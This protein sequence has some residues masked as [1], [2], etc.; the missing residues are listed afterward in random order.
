MP[1]DEKS[2]E[3]EDVSS[4][5]KTPQAIT[6]T[7]MAP[8][9]LESPSYRS[10]VTSSAEMENNAEGNSSLVVV[11]GD[12]G[13]ITVSESTKDLLQTVTETH[14]GTEDLP[15]IS[16][17]E[18]AAE[19]TNEQSTIHL[20]TKNEQLDTDK[21][22]ECDENEGIEETSGCRCLICNSV[23]QDEVVPV[24]KSM[25]IASQRKVSVYL[26]NLVGHKLTSRKAH[27][28]IICSHCF[29]LLNRLDLLEVEIRDTKELIVNKYQETVAIYGGRARKRKPVAAKKPDYVFPKIEPENE[30]EQAIALEM[31][32]TFEPQVDD[33]MEEEHDQK[34]DR[35]TKDE[36][37]EPEYKR[38][39]IKR[40]P[41]EP[42][43][44]GPPK[45]KRG[46]P[47]KDMSKSKGKLLED[48][49][50]L[51]STIHPSMRRTVSV[52]AIFKKCPHCTTIFME[53]TQLAIHLAQEHA[54][55]QKERHCQRCRRRFLTYED[56]TACEPCL[57]SLRQIALLSRKHKEVCVGSNTVSTFNC[58][59]CKASFNSRVL[60]E[61]HCLSTGHNMD[62]FR[63]THQ[64]INDK[65]VIKCN[66]PMS[67]TDFKRDTK[68]SEDESLD[69]EKFQ[70]TKEWISSVK[71]IRKLR[72]IKKNQRACNVC[73]TEFGS[74][75]TLYSH[76]RTTHPTLFP[77]ECGICKQRFSSE[78][79]AREHERRHAMGDLQCPAC[80]LRFSHISHLHHHARNQHPDFTDYRC[81]YCDAVTPSVD[82]LQSHIKIHHGDQLG[83]PAAFTC[84]TCKETF[85][86]GK[87]LASHRSSRHPGNTECSICGAKVGSR[88]LKKHINAV[89]TKEKVHKCNE[90]GV[91]FY[92]RTSLTGHQRRHHSPRKFFCHLCG[93]G[94]VHNVELQRHLKAHRDERDFKCEFCS[95]SFLKAVDLTYHRRSHTGERPHQCDLCP[96]SFIRPLGLRK[97]MM[98][99]SSFKK[100]K[101]IKYSKK[102]IDELTSSV[103][104]Q[105]SEEHTAGTGSVIKSNMKATETADRIN[106]SHLPPVINL[107]QPLQ[108]FPSND[109]VS[110][111]L[112]QPQ[113]QLEAQVEQL[114][115]DELQVQQL[116]VTDLDSSQ[117]EL[118][119][120]V[121]D[122][123]D[124]ELLQMSS[125][126]LLE[127]TEVQERDETIRTVTG[128]T[129]VQNEQIE[130]SQSS[131][132]VQVIYVVENILNPSICYHK[133]LENCSK[134][135]GNNYE[136]YF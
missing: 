27:S 34:D 64:T 45:R 11:G 93:K 79:S 106:E 112:S 26:G 68:A 59:H 136:N 14:M 111:D 12:G 49:S 83:L 47:R 15:V 114:E 90:C 8:S 18:S 132:P 28:D 104:N 102:K 134:C 6:I 84:K 37:W 69:G 29:S 35:D 99:H 3:E 115:P 21:G 135:R 65:P 72:L 31:D 73:H 124:G 95:R 86:T 75:S 121:E 96:E 71:K 103:I 58:S 133:S 30:D 23:L 85:H 129:Q 87:A 7:I 48:N 109:L 50:H 61:L 119:Q 39:R 16:N 100:G 33:L 110:Q 36:E 118:S 127:A 17:I 32:E 78:I 107:A 77:Y 74:V 105:I 91:E 56:N 94:Y 125:D 63:Y 131:Q 2:K 113:E 51:E 62:S 9:A 25:T 43:P 81:Q 76:L 97:H 53:N 55:H 41:S 44:R 67:N 98:K 66:E 88:Y 89:H 52:P 22:D 54:K 122:L 123:N 60:V 42:D 130:N 80:P 57:L 24:F 40:D 1:S 46:R 70:D 92:S 126:L 101:R 128:S 38:P 13:T 20:V 117:L 10:L 116:S 108:S 82:A 4:N 120:V 5:Q 19:D